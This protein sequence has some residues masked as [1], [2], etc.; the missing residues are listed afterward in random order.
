MDVTNSRHGQLDKLFRLEEELTD[1]WHVDEFATVLE[2]QLSASPEVDL[3]SFDAAS[4]DRLLSRSPAT[5]PGPKTF[6]GL[7]QQSNPCIEWLDLTKRFAKAAARDGRLPPEIAAV[8]YL[9]AICAAQVRGHQL[10]TELDSDSLHRK[11]TW[12]TS[13]PWL[14]EEL[15]QLLR[16]AMAT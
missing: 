7:L 9:A 13:Q 8:L 14:D 4:V 5:G 3:R 2:H 15:R 10:I 11:I 6:R 12:A 1:L 16:D